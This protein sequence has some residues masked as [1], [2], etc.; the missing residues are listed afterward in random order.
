MIGPRKCINKYLISN[1]AITYHLIFFL[2]C[3]CVCWCQDSKHLNTVLCQTFIFCYLWAIGGNLTNS[4]WDAFDTFIRQQ[5]EEN[6]SA[7]VY[8]YAHT[9]RYTLT[10]W[11]VSCTILYCDIC[12]HH[13]VITKWHT[14][15]Q[16]CHSCVSCTEFFLSL[17]CIT[18]S[19]IHFSAHL[20]VLTW[21]MCLKVNS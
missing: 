5:F 13:I 21:N 20:L 9:H 6:S 7:K 1:H 19:P 8:T 16:K 10:R 18:E 3:V 11:R 17:I 12:R 15:R 14:S 2:F 4:N